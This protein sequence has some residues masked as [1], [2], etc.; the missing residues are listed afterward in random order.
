MSHKLRMA[1]VAVMLAFAATGAAHARPINY[2]HQH[3]H[4]G[5]A[6]PV[7]SFSD[8]RGGGFAWSA[9]RDGYDGSRYWWGGDCWPTEPGSCN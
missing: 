1:T 2:Q 7:S 9:H 6:G 4:A 5:Y 8:A 3:F